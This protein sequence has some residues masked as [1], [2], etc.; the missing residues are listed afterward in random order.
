MSFSTK[1]RNEQNVRYRKQL[2]WEMDT[3]KSNALYTL[4]DDDYQGLPSF[5]RLY[6]ETNDITEY[7]QATTLLD[8]VE[9][10]DMLCEGEWFQPYLNKMRRALN[11]KLKAEAVSML[12]QDALSESKTSHAALKFLVQSGYDSSGPERRR[13]GRPSK[14]EIA[15]AAAEV[16]EKSQS[17]DDDFDRVQKVVNLR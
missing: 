3:D 14:A 7:T 10:W 1:F 12:R 5:Y 6:L 2:F 11:L 16:N 4:K 17:I 13:A 9:H 8:G 15:R